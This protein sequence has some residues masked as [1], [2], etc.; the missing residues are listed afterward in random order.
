MSSSKK[1]D[2]PGSRVLRMY[3]S[4]AIFENLSNPDSSMC[5][6]AS[7]IKEGGKPEFSLCDRS[8]LQDL[9]GPS[10]VIPFEAI[11]GFYE[12][13]S[14]QYVSLVVESEP[15]VTLG[16]KGQERTPGGNAFNYSLRKVKKF[17]V[18]PLFRNGRVLSESKQRDENRYL[19]LLH[20]GFSEHQFFFS[21]YHHVTLSQQRIAKLAPADY[22]A[23]LFTNADPHFFWNSNLVGGLVD[24]GEK[25]AS[26]W[27]V[28]FMSAYVEYRPDLE[29]E[30]VK[31]NMLFI[32]RRS[33]M[34]QGCRFTKRGID[35]NGHVA[36]F[37]E[38]EQLLIF[39]DGKITSFTQVRGS[40]PLLWS[41]PVCMK[42]EPAVYIEQDHIKESREFAQKHV[43]S[44]C[45]LYS[46][47]STPRKSGVTFINLIDQK[48]DQKRLGIAFKE[49]FEYVAEKNCYHQNQNQKSLK[50]IWFDFHAE[51]KKKGGW[52]NLWRLMELADES[53][54]AHKWFQ[55]EASGKVSSW[56][57]GVM[58]VNCMDNLDRTN[59]A[60]S[61]F[62]R[63]N[64]MLQLGHNP[65]VGPDTALNS[66]YTSFEKIFK[67][68][69]ANNADA[70]SMGY[71]G[72]PALKTDFTRTGKSTF[73]GKINDGIHS[74]A[75]YYKN[76]LTDGHKQD[77]IDLLV[78]NY[79][80]DVAS[81]TSPFAPRPG[82]E[83]L[84]TNLT[85]VFV[86]MIVVFS[87]LMLLSPN[88]HD[89]A[90]LTH[91]LLVSAGVTALVL[92]YV[93]F[94]VVKKGSAIGERIVNRPCLLPEPRQQR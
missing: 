60:Q 76:N 4:R 83:S 40:I 79:R 52:N 47:N 9:G 70:V 38:T 59:V 78:G 8:H 36:N 77:A 34:R 62:A 94:R 42:Y 58:R 16:N 17:L 67:A 81:P 88:F 65:K 63:R 5:L 50:Y 26:E 66:K 31:F 92:F 21:F 32:T 30:G 84:S 87:A 45:E 37:A 74:V 61:L 85:K 80:P 2:K 75:R 23:P 57:V 6:Q 89:S 1:N 28:P 41:Q 91:H 11:F 19:Q 82:Q 35:D 22:N 39:P 29:V 69:W 25:G 15:Y 10:Q 20:M 13:L 3:D 12:L 86:L 73:K 53:F 64:I 27:I 71:A 54:Q 72:T 48:G 55:R 33:R 56:Q 14:G 49:V 43:D 90:T 7:L 44:L 93:M 18:V 68:L 24:C 51:C 46:D